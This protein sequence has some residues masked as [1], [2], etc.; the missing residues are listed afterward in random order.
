MCLG[1]L[2]HFAVL[3]FASVSPLALPGYQGSNKVGVF[4]GQQDVGTVLHPGNA[5]YDA[6]AGTYRIS[7][8]GD[9]MWFGE[10]DFHFVWKKMSGDVALS[11]DIA[12]VGA[13]GNNHRKAVLMIRQSLDGHSKAVDVAWH[14]DG[15]TSLQY[16]D[17]MGGN[18]HE[19]ESD[20][21]APKRV[22]IEKR[23][24]YVSAYVSDPGSERLRPAG[25]STKI[26]LAGDFYVGIGV[27]AHDKNVTET[28]VFSKV[29]V[30]QVRPVSGV[31]VPY[32]TLETIT[33][34]STD[35]R[36]EYVAPKHFESPNWSGDGTYLLF[37]QEG[38]IRK[39]VIGGG[40]PTVVPMGKA[41]K[42][43]GDHGISPDGTLLAISDATTDGTSRIYVVPVTGGSPKLVTKNGPSYSH[44]WSP[45]GKTLAFEGMRNGELQIYTI[46]VDGGTETQLTTVKGL[47]DGSEY[48]ADGRSIYFAS[49]RT[50]TMQLWKMAADGSGQE[51]V[52]TDDRS[53]W[54]PHVSPDGKW[55][56]F[57]AYQK[58]VQGHPANVDVELRLMSTADG[59]VKL[60]AK[61]LGG[62]GTIN[63][64]SWSPDSKKLA[65]VSYS[66]IPQEDIS[67]E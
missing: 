48:A 9:N 39:R 65:F 8:S 55:V 12:F 26:S 51:R 14:G 40:E 54:F 27:S 37:S 30:E 6:A 19:V 5:I 1:C 28:A 46:P 38:E 60:L 67:P 58:D 7:G 3:V 10:D 63:G 17:E 34:G 53:D 44:G 22:R 23:G 41:T 24:D 16:R 59:K 2:R 35:R 47:N 49:E 21:S 66:M 42:I 11:A 4:E 31:P 62:R 56:A 33:V 64:P 15:L 18:T 25:A 45:D 29:K 50:G 32:S 36:I 13:A 61:L 20:L 57:L 43:L 52:L